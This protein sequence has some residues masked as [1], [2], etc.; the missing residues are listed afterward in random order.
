[1][2]IK[3]KYYKKR[4]SIRISKEEHE[5]FH[6]FAKES[7]LKFSVWV[8]NWLFLYGT[9]KER[10]FISSFIRMRDKTEQIIENDRQLMK[11]VSNAVHI[12]VRMVNRS[13]KHMTNFSEPELGQ[14]FRDRKKLLKIS[15][16]IR[17]LSNFS[18]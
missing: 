18:K 5:L 10:K 9:T 1:M 16:D 8:R 17:K 11:L 2:N 6:Q 3:P 14:H 13:K 12:A 15:N 4:L 7:E